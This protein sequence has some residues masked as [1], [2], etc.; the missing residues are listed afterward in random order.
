MRG[1]GCSYVSAIHRFL[2]PAKKKRNCLFQEVWFSK[3]LA[4]NRSNRVDLVLQLSADV[5]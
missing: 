5:V 2:K 1:L 3:P 4:Q